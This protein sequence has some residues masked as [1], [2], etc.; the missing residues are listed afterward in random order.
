TVT[1]AAALVPKRLFTVRSVKPP[2]LVLVTMTSP[3]MS[4]T[5]RLRL[6]IRTCSPASSVSSVRDSPARVARTSTRLADP[7]VV[8][9]MP[10]LNALPWSVTLRLPSSVVIPRPLA[11]VSTVESAA[12]SR[13][14]SSVNREPEAAGA[15]GIRGDVEL[16]Q[17]RGSGRDGRAEND[18]VA[19]ATR[20]LDCRGGGGGQDLDARLRGIEIKRAGIA[21]IAGG[22][23]VVHQQ[24]RNRV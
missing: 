19:V 9:A 5:L 4:C 20:D 7:P 15:G 2:G 23:A 17:Q 3:R 21:L 13:G 6:L 24:A 12:V 10:L 8:R 14:A 1:A 18:G 11:A 16:G 22:E